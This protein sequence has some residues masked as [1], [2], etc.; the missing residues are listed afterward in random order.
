MIKKISNIKITP[1]YC[2]GVQKIECNVYGGKWG[3]GANFKKNCKQCQKLSINFWESLDLKPIKLSKFI[4]KKK[5]EQIENFVEK[6]NINFLKIYKKKNINFS[7]LTRQLVCNNYLTN[8]IDEIEN[9]D[10]LYKSH[11]KI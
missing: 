6:K 7:K 3:G 11:L 5:F 10:F 4:N 1:I 8:N 9:Y 2:D